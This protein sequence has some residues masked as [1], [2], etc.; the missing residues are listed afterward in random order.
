MT[1]NWNKAA[2]RLKRDVNEHG[3]FLTIQKDALKKR[4]DI[5][6]L[7]VNNSEELRRTLEEHDM[8]VI[9][10]PHKAGTSLRVYDVETDIGKIA[11][12]V[13]YPQDVP[14]TAL[15]DAVNLHERAI[16]G[17][18]KRSVVVP[19]LLALDVFLQ[20][21]IGRPPE[22]WEDLDD[23]RELYQLVD[24]L[25]ASL[26]LPAAD[27]QTVRLAGAVCACRPHGPRWEGAPAGLS[28]ALTEAV[29]KQKD[30]FDGVL[31][32]AA[33]HLFGSTVIPSCDVD[34]GRL[35]L[36]YRREAQGDI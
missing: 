16:A 12:A 9:P 24:A 7:G 25:A 32:E 6:A 27:A 28:A 4:F 34:L 2:E 8:I 18:K 17:K 33:K 20:L 3:G 13:A 29:R 5:G 10:H 22:D 19:W 26:E 31:R 15:V 21:V 35:G 11:R 1:I 23:G 14:E 30:I 36:R